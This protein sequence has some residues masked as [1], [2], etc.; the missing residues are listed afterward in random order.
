MVATPED[1]FQI[2]RR[3]LFNYSLPHSTGQSRHAPTTPQH[4]VRSQISTHSSPESLHVSQSNQIDPFARLLDHIMQSSSQ[5]QIPGFSAEQVN[6]LTA[7]LSAVIDSKLEAFSRRLSQP[8]K[9]EQAKKFYLKWL[10]YERSLTQSATQRVTQPASQQA[11]Q[12]AR[13]LAKELAKQLAKQLA[14]QQKKKRNEKTRKQY[15]RRT[16]HK[17]NTK[18]NAETIAEKSS[19]IQAISTKKLGTLSS[20]PRQILS[21]QVLSTI[22]RQ[23]ITQDSHPTEQITVFWPAISTCTMIWSTIELSKQEKDLLERSQPNHHGHLQ[24]KD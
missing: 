3:R 6:G 14:T 17:A 16:L 9:Q 22:A 19:N 20:I 15:K 13:Q 5:S 10:E 11:K 2:I 24:V 8:V 1:L 23:I 4:Q 7:Y 12:P 18:A 21:H